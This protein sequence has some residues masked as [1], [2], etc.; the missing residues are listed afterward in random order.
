MVKFIVYL[1]IAK[2]KTTETKN[3]LIRPE[4]E[5]PAWYSIAGGLGNLEISLEEN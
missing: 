4:N 2:T 5:E 3:W 1:V